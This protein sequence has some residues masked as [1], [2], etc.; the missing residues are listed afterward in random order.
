M[1][2]S[3]SSSGA[4]GGT[5]SPAIGQ[6]VNGAIVLDAGNPTCADLAAQYAPGETWFQV[7]LDR[8]PKAAESLGDGVISVSLTN[9]TTRTFDW[10]ASRG[11][12]AVLVKSGT[13]GN[14][15]YLYTPE[16]SSGSG[17]TPGSLQDISHITF[18]Y[19]VELQVSETAAT[20]FTRDYDWT[21]A[22]SVD[23]PSVTLDQ[24]G[25]TT[26]NYASTA[27]KDAGTDS[28]W[29]IAG[30]ISVTNPHPLTPASGITVADSLS[31]H[32]AIDVVCPAT[33][34]A[35][36]ASM[37]C[38]YGPVALATGSS[39]TNT[40]T[41][42]STT[43]GIAQGVD[44]TDIAFT[45]PT[46]VLDNAVTVADTYAAAG[47]LGSGI[48][49]SRN[50]TYSREILA[51]DL[52]CGANVIGNTVSLAT[53]D[54]ST[55]TASVTVTATL[56]CATVTPAPTPAP[57]P[58]PPPAPVVGCAYSQGYWST[59]S[60]QGPAKYDSTWAK[61][62][63]NTPFYK[64]GN[65]YI[66]EIGMPAKGNAYR[67]LSS[68][69]IAAKLNMLAGAAA[70]AGVDMG[71][72]ESFYALYTPAQVDAMK[73]SDAVRKQALAWASTL[74]SYNNGRLNV[75]HCGS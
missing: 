70:P 37:T 67:I 66:A 52:A 28:D 32:G 43:Y 16:A 8:A 5:T 57:P 18:C 27:T 44:T 9:G 47:T 17:T 65:S 19:D 45:T 56:N 6:N 72:I 69:F 62:G 51:S 36:L 25:Q 20:A 71:A 21:I 10:T 60:S 40:A 58:P 13:M 39:R 75:S 34:L 38:K 46:T 35:P 74:D 2:T 55:E 59:H 15:F 64:S 61:I 49:S 63:E 3:S 29:T 4:S 12:D 1:S 30:T 11:V 14:N 23:R 26:V 73:G 53:D 24:G 33:S 68:Q 42:R 31:E 50:F 7:K 48:T 41:A 54:G 22:A